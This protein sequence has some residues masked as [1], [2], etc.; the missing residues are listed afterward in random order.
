MPLH[1][2]QSLHIFVVASGDSRCGLRFV[3][4]L[5]AIYLP[6]DDY[7]PTG[8]SREAV[9]G[10][11]DPVPPIILRAYTRIVRW[12]GSLQN[13]TAQ[14]ACGTGLSVLAGGEMSFIGM[15]KSNELHFVDQLSHRYGAGTAPKGTRPAGVAPTGRDEAQ[16]STAISACNQ[17]RRRT[18]HGPHSSRW[19]AR[20]AVRNLRAALRLA[21][22]QFRT[23]DRGPSPCNSCRCTGSDC[24]MARPQTTKR[25]LNLRRAQRRVG[26]HHLHRGLRS[27][28]A[29]VPRPTRLACKRYRRAHAK[30]HIATTHI[31]APHPSH[32]LL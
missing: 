25:G 30:P 27:S 24:P 7:L 31:A 11:V 23:R 18:F 21:R 22:I 2:R 9:H 16:K 6:S 3:E 20:G 14:S 28:A 32:L 5:Q 19:L 26:V 8:R 1:R 17:T 10:S 15:E 13:A 12:R 4:A 29:S